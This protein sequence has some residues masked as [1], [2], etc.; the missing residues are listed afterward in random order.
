MIRAPVC[1]ER[2]HE[3]EP[4]WELPRRFRAPIIRTVTL[5]LEKKG[6]KSPFDIHLLR[7]IKFGNVLL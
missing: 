3:F 7:I 5:A 6:F 1:R 2:S 4:I